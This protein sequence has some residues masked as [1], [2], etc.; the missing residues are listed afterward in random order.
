MNKYE[1]LTG[2]DLEYKPGVVE[3][4][5]FEY[6]PLGENLNKG[7]IKDKKILKVIKFD[8]DLKY[9]SVHNFNK[10]NVSNFNE[11]LSIDS[12]FDTPDKFYKDFLKLKILKSSNKE[13][14]QKK[15]SVLKNASLL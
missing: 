1:Y 7:L 5:K 9:D 15:I 14:N 2:E 13:T 4:V 8:S 6:S 3:K 10:Y 11:I 12:K